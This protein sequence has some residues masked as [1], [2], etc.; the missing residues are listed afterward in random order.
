MS[1]LFTAFDDEVFGERTPVG[2][3]RFVAQETISL[4]RGA[5]FRECDAGVFAKL[6]FIPRR[7][8]SCPAETSQSA[9]I[10]CP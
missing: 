10:L 1:I 8:I 5:G 2:F 9:S 6:T 4:R 7:K 3:A